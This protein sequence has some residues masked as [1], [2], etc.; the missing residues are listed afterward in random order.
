MTKVIK[1]ALI[2]KV[3]NADGEE[4]DY[5]EV[6]RCLW[7]LQNETRDFKNNIIREC[8]EWYGFSNDYYKLNE[9]YPKE[10]DYFINADKDGVPKLDKDGK[11]KTYALDGF[12]Y[13]KYKNKLCL[14]T[15][16]SS[17]TLRTTVAAY[18]NDLKDMLRGDKSILS[19]RGNQPIDIANKSVGLKYDK[20]SDSFR[21]EISLLNKSGKKKYNIGLFDFDAI[22]KDNSTR[23]ILERCYD[24]IY[25]ISASKLIWNKKKKQWFLNLSYS[26]ERDAEKSEVDTDKIL[27]VNLGVI[28]PVCAS[29][30]GEKNRLIVD[31]SEIIEFRRRI[32]AR[33][34][35]LKKQAAVCGD[36]RIGHGYNTRMKPV[37][38]ISDKI[39]RF[40]DTYN[41]KVSRKVVD[42]AVKSN[43][44]TIQLENLKGITD[45]AEP[46]LKNW[47]YF[48]L[49]NKIEYKAKE[50]G[51]KI[52]YIEPAY[53]SQRCSKCGY[54]NAANHPTRE[55]FICGE[56]GF[57]TLHD[58]N[59]SQNIGIKQ[60]DKVIEESLKEIKKKNKKGDK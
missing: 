34:D 29:V 19:F 10:R 31:G 9:E 26:F 3:R 21:F 42:Y 5:K 13:D 16:N 1:I 30:H 7:D 40:R 45:D 6:C 11:V 4:L 47:S 27:G 57:R 24:K 17:A 59:A 37:L 58:Y 49:Q 54:I 38:K 20:D 25:K 44:G 51:I 41:H 8:W 35:S 53:T 60:I 15:A 12:I 55:L 32:E 23:T 43:C 50:N 56:C 48:D 14:Q 36:G 39:S 18:K 2:S 33:R 28:Y 22:V 52:V 46:F